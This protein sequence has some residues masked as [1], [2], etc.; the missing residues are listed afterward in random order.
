MERMLEQD[1]DNLQL[2]DWLAFMYYSNDE[3]DKA[4]ASYQRIIRLEPGNASQHYYLGNCYCKKGLL[5]EARREWKRFNALS[6][7]ANM[8]KRLENAS[9]N[10][11]P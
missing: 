9:S 7:E 5:E 1:P 3:V 11:N 8:L 2:L 6:R 4:I 10:F